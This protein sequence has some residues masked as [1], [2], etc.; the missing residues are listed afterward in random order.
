MSIEQAGL[1]E[2]ELMRTWNEAN[3]KI[4][5]D[6]T[7]PSWYAKEKRDDGD[8]DDDAA[9]DKARAW[10]DWKDDNPRGAGNKKATPCG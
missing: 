5:D 9:T 3:Q 6:A 1:A 2:M 10:D 8:S 7:R 4:A